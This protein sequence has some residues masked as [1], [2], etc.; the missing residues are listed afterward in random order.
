MA[1]VIPG[2][3]SGFIVVCYEDLGAWLGSRSTFEI[4]GDL[5]PLEFGD[6]EGDRIGHKSELASL[7][8]CKYT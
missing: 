1:R 7:G 2:L 4:W 3:R 5:F 6:F 8:S